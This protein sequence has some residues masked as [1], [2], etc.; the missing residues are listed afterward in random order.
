MQYKLSEFSIDHWLTA[1]HVREIKHK[2]MLQIIRY[3]FKNKSLRCKFQSIPSSKY[4]AQRTRSS[5]YTIVRIP[6]YHHIAPTSR[7]REGMARTL[8]KNQNFTKSANQKIKQ[9]KLVLNGITIRFRS[10]SDFSFHL[11]D[12]VPSTWSSSQCTEPAP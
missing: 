5:A 3:N 9:L 10:T 7:R 11:P 2:Q 1:Q 4:P 12:S 8:A 6:E